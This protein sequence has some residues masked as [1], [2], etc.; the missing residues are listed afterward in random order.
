[1]K[2]NAIS[3]G[4]SE[5]SICALLQ[6]SCQYLVDFDIGGNNLGSEVA[7]AL[8]NLSSTLRW[9]SLRR[10]GIG[11]MDVTK[12]DFEVIA[13][14]CKSLEH[15]DATS[16]HIISS[17]LSPYPVLA[18]HMS[19]LKSLCLVGWPPKSSGF[20]LLFQ[21]PWE[22]LEDLVL[23]NI[24]FYRNDNY[25]YKYDLDLDAAATFANCVKAHK[26]P[27]LKS[28]TLN[29]CPIYSA[30]LEKLFSVEWHTLTKCSLIYC[31]IREAHANALKASAPN[32]PAL[33][34][35]VMRDSVQGTGGVC[36]VGWI[37]GGHWKSLREF[38]CARFY[39]IDPLSDLISGGTQ[40]KENT[41][42]VF[43]NTE[44]IGEGAG[45]LFTRI[46]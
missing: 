26:L 21:S 37:V 40:W 5:A 2:A 20:E 42:I 1:M 28:F 29:C 17:D 10:L 35:L 31:Q 22:H 34:S 16:S 15:L 6:K 27:A 9:P 33:E 41:K 46:M 3:K 38:E 36:V 13:K 4:L 25:R 43:Y 30:T 45:T 7:K 18:T 11:Y 12:P 23:G 32:L 8:G 39:S 44:G 14:G 24:H 19:H